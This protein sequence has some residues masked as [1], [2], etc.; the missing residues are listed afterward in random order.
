MY[1]KIE[2]TLNIAQALSTHGGIDTNKFCDQLLGNQAQITQHFTCA[3]VEMW[4][5]YY[6]EMHPHQTLNEDVLPNGITDDDIKIVFE[7]F[8]KPLSA[9]SCSLTIVDP[10]AF[11]T[12]TNVALLVD[13]LSTNVKSKK[14]RFI[15]N[16]RNTNTSVEAD[17]KTQLTNIGFTVDVVN[18]TDIHDRYWY[19][20][21]KGFSCG[22]SFNGISRKTTMI[23][24]FPDQDL[25]D[26]IAIF[27]I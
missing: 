15:T 19:T 27:G 6:L 2:G 18:R 11:A 20:R 10:Y 16:S 8:F 25:S 14:V 3:E 24:I 5:K 9:E 13:I 4:R 23:N 22:T 17:I 26:I 1:F 12:G 7:K 21:M